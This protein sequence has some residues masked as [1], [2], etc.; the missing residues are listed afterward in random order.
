MDNF[1]IQYTGRQ[2]AEHLLNALQETYAVTTDWEGKKFSGIDLKWDYNQHT[3]WLTMDGYITKVQILFENKDPT[4]PQHS[5]HKHC[6]INYG[7]KAQFET[8][9]GDTSQPL[10][11]A[12]IKRVQGIDGCLLYYA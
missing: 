6:P 3:C 8:D 11:A 10:N 5:P 7:A 9:D 12:G 4:K 2:H 1:G